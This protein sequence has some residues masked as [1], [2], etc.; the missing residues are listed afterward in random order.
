M[1]SSAGAY[2]TEDISRGTHVTRAT[3]KPSSQGPSYATLPRGGQTWKGDV[4]EN[5]NS[6]YVS[7][8]MGIKDL[9]FSLYSFLISD[10]MPLG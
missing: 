2:T 3:F 7:E 4:D 6:T 10:H 8:G 5:F 9:L 1:P